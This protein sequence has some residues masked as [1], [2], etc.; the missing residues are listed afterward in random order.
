MKL[1]HVLS[2]NEKCWN[3][4]KR[5]YKYSPPHMVRKGTAIRQY[6]ILTAYWSIIRRAFEK[7]PRLLCRTAPFYYSSHAVSQVW[8]QELLACSILVLGSGKGSGSSR[9]H[10]LIGVKVDPLGAGD[11]HH[12][13]IQAAVCD[14]PDHTLCDQR[15]SV[16]RVMIL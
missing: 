13:P 6:S 16:N 9:R 10:G 14:Q 15:R 8:Q 5:F 11:L 2:K 7:E 1:K 3:L 4:N 12:G